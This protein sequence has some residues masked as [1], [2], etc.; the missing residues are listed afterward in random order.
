[1]VSPDR[2]IQTNYPGTHVLSGFA[3][4]E[5][6]KLVATMGRL[7]SA[8]FL[9]ALIAA[10]V[11]V[12]WPQLAGF[13]QAYGFAQAVSLRG[14]GIA[15]ALLAVLVCILLSSLIRPLRGFLAG[16]TT[17]LVLFSVANAAIL[18][19]RG[20][21]N[22]DFADTAPDPASI[23]AA[24]WNTLGNSAE[25]SVVAQFAVDVHAQVFSLPETTREATQQIA[26][27]IEQLGGP[28]MTVLHIALDDT[29]RARSTGLLI[30]ADLGEYS[31]TQE[32][33]QTSTL[34][35]VVAVPTGNTALPTIVAVH[36][37]PPLTETMDAWRSDLSWVTS[38][39]TRPNTILAG[40]FNAT[41]DHLGTAINCTDAALAT[42]HAA[43]GT[44]S[45]AFPALLGAPID[46]V[47]YTREWKATAM[48]VDQKHDDSGSDH[49]PIVARLSRG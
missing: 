17:I 24:A 6:D 29:T 15:V 10:S 39:C 20:V 27:T 4:D 46:H 11:L 43:L 33:G 18:I 41:V 36:T 23:T 21:G 28:R 45:T 13:E 7:I 5:T 44:W 47:M 42:G 31:L 32:L 12:T 19:T 3:Q 48:L 8:I 25:P 40:D 34:P 26:D 16:I 37:I 30:A 49:R 2:G 35:S 14:M 9:L 38:A 1:M 22:D